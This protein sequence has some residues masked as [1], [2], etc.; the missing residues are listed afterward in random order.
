MLA[1]SRYTYNAA[2]YISSCL[3]KCT[4]Y[5]WMQ[6]KDGVIDQTT[7]TNDTTGMTPEKCLEHCKLNHGAPTHKRYSFLVNSSVCFCAEEISDTMMAKPQEMCSYRCPGMKNKY[8]LKKKRD[9]IPICYTF[10]VTHSSSAGAPA[11]IRCTWL[12]A[13]VRPRRGL[14]SIATPKLR[15]C[16]SKRPLMN[17]LVK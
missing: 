4:P 17:A 10:Q 15:Q 13:R 8:D 5:I 9:P 7:M 3:L 11:T 16:K 1:V 6:D 14:E 2:Q 12:N